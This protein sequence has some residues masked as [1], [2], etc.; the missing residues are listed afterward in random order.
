MSRRHGGAQVTLARLWRALATSAVV[1]VGL[2]ELIEF[3]E[4]ASLAYQRNSQNAKS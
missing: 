2:V 3:R 1:P 4:L